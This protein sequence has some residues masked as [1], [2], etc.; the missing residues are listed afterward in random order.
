ML[1]N[2]HPAKS[3]SRIEMLGLEEDTGRHI[4]GVFIMSSVTKNWSE[5]NQAVGR[6]EAVKQ[7]PEQDQEM[8]KHRIQRS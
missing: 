1:Q 5:S 6:I 2:R 8:I 4:I 3:D 7:L